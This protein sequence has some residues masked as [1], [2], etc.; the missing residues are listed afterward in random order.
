MVR[1]SHSID[2]KNVMFTA[3]VRRILG[4]KAIVT[5]AGKCLSIIY[6]TLKNDWIYEDFPNFVLGDDAA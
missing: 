2:G 6:L 3:Y 4:G 5:L 1:R